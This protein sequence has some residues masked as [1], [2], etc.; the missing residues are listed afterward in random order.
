[1]AKLA[2]ITGS[3][4]GIGQALALLLLDKGYKVVGLA[5]NKTIDHPNFQHIPIDLSNLLAVKEFNFEI[6]SDEAILVN[7][8]GKIGEI[9][10]VG[11]VTDQEMESVMNINTIAPQI[12]SNKFI[13]RFKNNKGN[14]HILNISS[15][16]GKRA[17][18]S[19]ATYCASKAAIDLFSETIAAEFDWKEMDNWHIHS[20]APGVVDTKMQ[21]HIRSTD[22]S[23]FMHVENFKAYKDNAE[24]YSAEFVANKLFQVINDPSNFPQTII[25]VRD[26]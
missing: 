3:S 23:K 4:R 13:K 26:F 5:R 20:C 25:S 24:L 18:S 15:G 1:M 14:Y 10:P 22:Q 6:E 2:Y 9:A 16:A 11:E 21:E 19:W 8:A 17:I 7:N 12:L